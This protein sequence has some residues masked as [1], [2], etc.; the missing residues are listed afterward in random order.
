MLNR[1]RSGRKKNSTDLRRLEQIKAD[2]GEVLIVTGLRLVSP[3][4]AYIECRC[5]RFAARL[6]CIEVMGVFR[7]FFLKG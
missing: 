4:L 3:P 2:G 5:A 1:C 6:R 7:D